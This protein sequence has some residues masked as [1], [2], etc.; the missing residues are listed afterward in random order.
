MLVLSGYAQVIMVA[1]V[2][3]A[4]VE[5]ISKVLY[6]ISRD[7]RQLIKVSHLWQPDATIV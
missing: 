2:S 6:R 7:N 3:A 5:A 1:V 4:D